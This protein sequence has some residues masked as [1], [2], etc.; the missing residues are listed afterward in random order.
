MTSTIVF[1]WVL[2]KKFSRFS[3]I[4][5]REHSA[6]PLAA[7]P[8]YFQRWKKYLDHSP[9]NIIWR[10]NSSYKCMDSFISNR[11]FYKHVLIC[12]GKMV[13]EN[14]YEGSHCNFVRG[15]ISQY[16]TWDIRKWPDSSWQSPQP[17]ARASSYAPSL[18]TLKRGLNL[19]RHIYAYTY[20]HVK[21]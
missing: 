17:V 6:W 9:Q 4:L 16:L 1:S 2:L 14:E 7:P 5:T 21:V 13:Q 10:H 12:K 18:L 11:I 15:Y 3:S 19:I 8:G 20:I